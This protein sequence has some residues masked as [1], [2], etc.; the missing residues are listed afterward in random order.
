MTRS[1]KS[2]KPSGGV[3]GKRSGRPSADY[4]EN[5]HKL[6]KLMSSYFAGA[7]ND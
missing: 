5:F 3:L 7:N 2:N 4:D 6:P 1:N